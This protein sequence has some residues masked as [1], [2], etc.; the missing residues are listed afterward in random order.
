[1]KRNLQEPTGVEE[2]DGDAGDG[3][4][5]EEKSGCRLIAQD[6]TIEFLVYFLH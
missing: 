3:L 1:M 2:E 4:D 6:V 5:L